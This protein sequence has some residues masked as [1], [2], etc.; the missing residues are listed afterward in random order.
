MYTNTSFKLYSISTD[1]IDRYLEIYK[2]VGYQNLFFEIEYPNNFDATQFTKE[3][4][5]KYGLN[6]IPK[7]VIKPKSLNQFRE[8]LSRIN[9][10]KDYAIAVES[11][12]KEILSFATHDSRI[13]II[14]LGSIELVKELTPGIISLLKQNAGK[15]FLEISLIDTINSRNYQRSKSFREIFKII[16]MASKNEKLIVFGGHELKLNYI[17]GPKEIISIFN[18]IFD[19]SNEKAKRF[20]RENPQLLI[21]KI[22]Q[23]TDKDFIETGV[24][25]IDHQNL[26]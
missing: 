13:D 24:Q 16:S 11:S 7:L 10:F 6:L 3:K 1:Q 25:I 2:W 26:N 9:Q 14:S 5:I 8:I 19:I 20:V 4:N 18:S 15:K 21:D 12:D 23:R 17:R 22:K